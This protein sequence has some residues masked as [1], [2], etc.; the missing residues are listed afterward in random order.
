[1][2]ALIQVEMDA[3]V[4]RH[5]I[6]FAGSRRKQATRWL[7]GVGIVAYLAFAWWFF[8]IGTVLAN[9]NWGIA[10]IYLA[11]WVSYETRPNIDFTDDGLHV[12]YP[13]FSAYNENRQ[14]AWIELQDVRSP[15]VAGQVSMTIGDGTVEIVPGRV[16]ARRGSET[17][18]IV[19]S[20]EQTVSAEGPLP[21]WAEQDASGDSITL[22]FGFA[23][24]VEVEGDEGGVVVDGRGPDGLGPLGRRDVRRH[25]G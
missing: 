20:P 25:G 1:M 13:R 16:T 23:G 11:D 19:I 2:A 15:G 7:I 3:I 12:Q 4:G 10:G 24:S 21:Q 14:P 22:R 6:V 9:G 18:A 8:A 5:P 17:V